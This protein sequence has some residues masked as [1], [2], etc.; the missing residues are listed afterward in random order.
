[1]ICL[2]VC[3]LWMYMMT[4]DFIHWAS[5]S[6]PN[7]VSMMQVI[8]LHRTQAGRLDPQDPPPPHDSICICHEFVYMNMELVARV[9]FGWY[10]FIRCLIWYERHVICE[11]LWTHSNWGR[12]WG[13]RL[14]L[15]CMIDIQVYMIVNMSMYLQVTWWMLVRCWDVVIDACV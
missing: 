8:A 13:S 10:V 3:S 9:L 5:R 4:S 6:S 14:W 12:A 2:L 1:M 15:K 11:C 7:S